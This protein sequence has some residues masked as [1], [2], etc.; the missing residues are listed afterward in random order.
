MIEGVVMENKE[1]NRTI[2][3]DSCNAEF[4]EGTKF[5]TECGKLVENDSEIDENLSEQNIVCPKCQAEVSPGIKFCEECGTKIENIPTSNNQTTCPKCYA[6]IPP[7]TSFCEECGTKIDTLNNSNQET[8]CPKCYAEVPPG[9]SFC[10]ECGTKIGSSSNHTTCPKC[11]TDVE[12]GETF[13][14]ECGTSLTVKKN[15]SSANINQE[16]KKKRESSSRNVPPIDETLG[17]VVKSGKGLMKGLGGF[18]DKAASGIDK[19]LNQSNKSE[20]LSNKNINERIQKRREKEKVIPGFLVCDAC[21]GYY[22]L[23]AEEAP[24]DFSDECECGGNLEHKSKLE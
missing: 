2:R 13:C 19:N 17:N 24:D 9:T 11:Y 22:E 6:D 3:C 1:S 5:C 10:I 7:G 14:T 16:L 18:L 21:G 20:S 15:A 4:S 23:Q 8:T 12:P